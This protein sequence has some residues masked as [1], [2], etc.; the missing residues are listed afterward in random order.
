MITLI[1][2]SVIVLFFAIQTRRSLVAA[3]KGSVGYNILIINLENHEVASS[4]F[5]VLLIPLYLVVFWARAGFP[6]GALCLIG[7]TVAIASLLLLIMYWR[8][9]KGD[10]EDS[11]AELILVT[12]L[13]L[14]L[15]TV[16][17]GIL[18]EPMWYAANHLWFLPQ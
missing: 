1:V 17:Y 18:W 11:K 15:V 14:S 4:F 8:G 5:I 9:S 3:K 7:L 16:V 13:I 2:V 10:Q 6:S 12:I